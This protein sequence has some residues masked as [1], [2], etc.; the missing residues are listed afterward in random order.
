MSNKFNEAL[1]IRNTGTWAKIKPEHKFDSSKFSK[2]TVLNDIPILSPKIDEMIKKINELDAQDIANE[3]K[4]Y[5]HI[6]YSDVAGVYGAKM[7]A[8]SLIANNFSLVYSN[9]FALRQDIIDKNKTFGL[10]TTSTVYQKPLT[11]GL[12]KKMMTYMNERPSNING[13]NMRIIILDSGYKEGLDVFDVKYMHILEPLVT[14]A[15]HTQVVGRGTRYCGQSGLPFIPKVGWT[16]NIYR[17]NI[18]YDNDMTVHDLYLKHSGKNISAFNFTVDIEAIMIASAVDTPLTENLHILREKNN[19][20]Y[21][22]LMIKSNKNDKPQRKDYIQVVNNIRGKIY[23]ND[24]LIDCKK[25]CNGVLEDFPSANA[26]LIIAIVFIIEKVDKRFDNINVGNKK[27]YF[28]NI[29]NKVNNIKDRDLITYLNNKNPKPLLCNIIDKN[30]NFCDTINKLWMNPINFLKLYGDNIIDKLNHYKKENI[31]NDKNY[32]DAMRFITDYKNKLINKKPV[33]EPEP[34]KTKLNNIEL[35]KYVEKHYASY[36]W[37]NIDIVNKCIISDD[38]VEKEKDK[39]EYKLVTFS[40]T[41]SF[42][43]KFLTPQSPYKGM[44]LYHSVG[45]GK[46]CTAISTATNTFDKQGYKI[47]WVTRHT[48]KEDI[49]KNMFDNIC[50][51]IIQE[52][53][54]NG[55]ILPSTKAKRMEFLGKNWLQPISYKQFTN[56]IRGQNK[57][58]KQM[59]EINGAKDPF[60]KTLIIIDE[61]HKIYSSSLS[62]LE[63]P[64]PEVLQNMIQNSYKVSGK[65]SLKLLLMTATPITDDPMS[66]VKILNLLLENNERFPEDFETFKT[67]LC[68]ENGLF[69][70]KGS[71]EFMNRVAGLISYIDRTNDRSQ[72]AYPAINDILIDINRQHNDDH[73]LSELNKNIEEQE[74]KLNDQNLKKDEIKEIKNNIKKLKKDKKFANKLKDEPKNIIDFL[75]NCFVKERTIKKPRVKEGKKQHK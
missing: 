62:A 22:L 36:K 51:I 46:T 4:Y 20:F 72:F 71:Q 48:L 9:K 12:K 16:L 26:L 19:R 23:N 34:P 49:W 70:D 25:K 37:N 1:C 52:R 27:I 30:Q 59:V 14:K 5:K 42:V 50:N 8:S 65:D 32:A 29:K 45:S 57:Y 6:I 56:L 15:E 24:E 64:K 21:D 17:Y 69:T 63:K 54:K 33:L 66:S 2:D 60:R 10:L 73:G 13:E 7:V 44:L 67:A 43:Q 55:E 41:Q 11:I 18:K 58:Y 61:I 75:N 39:K 38:D 53:L 40:N 28:G 35:Y 74:N 47:L 31:I 3:N 68:N